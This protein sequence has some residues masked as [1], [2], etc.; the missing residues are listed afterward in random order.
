MLWHSAGRKGMGMVGP[1]EAQRE[2]AYIAC[3]LS[4]LFSI[5]GGIEETRKPPTHL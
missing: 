2:L 1:G 4:F 3:F 5:V